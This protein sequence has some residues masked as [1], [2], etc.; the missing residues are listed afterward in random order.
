VVRGRT[1]RT[2][3]AVGVHRYRLI[4]CVTDETIPTRTIGKANAISTASTVRDRYVERGNGLIA[5]ALLIV[6]REMNCAVWVLAD[7]VACSRRRSRTR[8]VQAGSSPY[9]RS[10]QYGCVQVTPNRRALDVFP[11]VAPATSLRGLVLRISSP[12]CSQ[13]GE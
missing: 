11:S 1:K 7:G 9:L 2:E 10:R 6:V 13:R 5:T 4:P 12:D 8:G 3:N